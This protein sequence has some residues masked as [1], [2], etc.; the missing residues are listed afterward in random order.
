[1]KRVLFPFVGDTVGGSHISTLELALGLDG[2]RFE[3]VVAVHREGP[4]PGDQ[5]RQWF[6]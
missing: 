2:G 4:L 3:A 5:D 1:M 6:F